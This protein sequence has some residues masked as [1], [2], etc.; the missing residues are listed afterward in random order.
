M[1]ALGMRFDDRVT[2]DLS[3][4]APHARKIHVDLDAAELNKLISV[5][6]AVHADLQ[7]ALLDLLPL[8]DKR[9]RKEWHEVVSEWWEESRAVDVINQH[10]EDAKLTMP[11]V[12]DAIRRSTHGEAIVVT[13]VGQHQM[14]AAQYYRFD[15]PN[16]FITSGGLGTMGFG[17]P[18]AL[19]AQ[20]ARP[21]AE[22]W[23]MVGDGGLQMTVQELATVVQE[24]LPIKIALCDN[25]YLGMVRQ[26]QE[27]VYDQNY[28]STRLVN[29]DF[30]KLAE[31]YGIRAWR[32]GDHDQAASAI[33]QA[34][35]H[36][37]PALID[38]QVVKE[39]EG[40]NVYPMV[41]AGAALHEMIR[42]PY[43]TKVGER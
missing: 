7:R 23:A 25:G 18:A 11:H 29:P 15:R 2:G 12:I 14:W 19:G 9:D 16:A 6:V 32:A 35:A 10:D 37:G 38:F 33:D 24:Q 3:R 34:R 5:D 30:V 27:I 41:P 20:I 43:P 1:I 28:E 40:G 42:R 4:Y 13:D 31:A 36:R 21:D 39:G 17:L 26:W 22:V 8:V